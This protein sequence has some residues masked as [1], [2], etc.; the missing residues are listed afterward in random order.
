MVVHFDTQ[1]MR[2][3]FSVIL[4]FGSFSSHSI[5]DPVED[6]QALLDFLDNIHHSHHVNWNKNSSVCDNWTGVTCDS[7]HSRVIALGLTGVG[8]RGSIPPNTLSRL[9]A[10]QILC[11]R[12][13]ALSGSFPSDFLQLKNLTSL[14]L[15]S[16]EFSG[17][18]LLDFSVWE[19]LTILDLSDNHF[20]GS[21]PSSISN[22]THLT[23]LNLSNNS[24]SGDI[25]DINVPSLKQLDL[26]NNDLSGIV[27]RSLQSFPS[28]AFSGNNL[29]WENATTAL[30]PTLPIHPPRTHASKRCKKLSESAILGMAL[31]GSALVFVIIA[32]LMICYSKKEKKTELPIKFQKKERSLE[33]KD[34]EPQGED[35]K[36]VFFEGCDL[37]FDLEDLLRASAELLGKGSFG[38][39]YKAALEDA[40]TVAVKRLKDVTVAKKEF[41]QQIG[42]I[43]NLRHANVSPL[44][45][46]YYSK[47]EKLVVYDYYEQGSVST[48]LHGN[49]VEGRI[50]LDWE[51]RLKIIIGTARGIVHIHFQNG[52]KLVLGNIKTSNIFLNS[53]GYGCISDAGL[54]T[55]MSP[56]VPV[57]MRAAGYR[58]PEVTD[59]RKATQASD[60]YSFGVLVLELLTGKSPLQATGGDEVVHLV[61]WVHSVVREEWTA[62]VFDIQLLRYPGIEEELVETLQIGLNCVSRT[63][64]KR[65]KMAEVVEMVEAIRQSSTSN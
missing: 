23:S 56:A 53:Q 5:A 1:K 43:G 44:R 58:A 37:A 21:I 55:L 20:S 57:G 4:F 9:S 50:P 47:D 39:T 14:V 19:N 33:K 6:K 15:Q 13:N 8:F 42:V 27:P 64:D 45:A 29:S 12:S 65:P 51:T 24:L 63:P 17:A 10:V 3:I 35:N 31:G 25:P 61:R 54:T 34:G 40:T 2:L 49:S 11:L 48:M 60:V 18:L 52:G 62:E 59:I 38:I 7:N 26:A 36:L 30:R 41:E 46:Y 28:W 16:N 32:L 22:L